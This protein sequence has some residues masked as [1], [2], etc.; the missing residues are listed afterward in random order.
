M[1]LAHANQLSLG[2]G[3]SSQVLPAQKQTE[4]NSEVLSGACSL[5]MVLKVR[6]GVQDNCLVHGLFIHNK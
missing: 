4:K 2:L 6:P 3:S 5:W 1:P